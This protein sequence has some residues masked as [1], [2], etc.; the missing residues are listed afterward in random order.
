[1]SSR[2]IEIE[3][4]R[5]KAP[6]APDEELGVYKVVRWTW[7]QKQEAIMRGSKV[8]DR[9]R[10]LIE[11]DLIDFQ[12]EQ[13]ISCVKPPKGLT[14]DKD[15]MDQLDTDVGDLLLEACRRV[16]GTTLS[17]RASFLEPSEPKENTP[18]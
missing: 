6:F 11:L 4:T 9:D 12:V 16:N 3:I 10:G 18:G 5:E 17:E 15:R 13:I 2:E 8:L 14:L 1:M 7:R